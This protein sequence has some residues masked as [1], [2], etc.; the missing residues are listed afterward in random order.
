MKK[1]LIIGKNAYLAEN[2]KFDENEYNVDKI[3]RPLEVGLD[4]YADYDFIINFCIQPEH[5]SRLLPENEMIDVKIAKNLSHTKFIFLSSRKVYGSSPIL[6]EYREDD[7]L[8]PFDFYSKNKVNIEQRLREILGNKLLVLRTGN[9]VGLPPKRNCPT[10]VSWLQS[11]LKNND[12]VIVT[13]N[14]EA[15]K[16]YITKDYF[17]YVLQ[18]AVKQNLSGTYNVGA[19]FAYTTEELMKNLVDEQR[20]MF[21]PLE[22]ISEQFILNCDKLHTK[23]KPLTREEFLNECNTMKNKLMCV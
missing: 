20:L 11:E 13:V 14:K 22:K 3:H 10:F 5:F 23:I 8:K 21:S 16:D 12:K 15:K 17:H 6:K 2:I 1:I 4:K 9:I 19:G 18:E 7:K